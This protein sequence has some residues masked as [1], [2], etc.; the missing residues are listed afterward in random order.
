MSVYL[1]ALG[2]AAL[3]GVGDAL[4]SWDASLAGSMTLQVPAET[5]AARLKTVVA[6]L[7]QTHGL[8]EVRLLEPEETARLVQPWLGPALAAGRLPVPQ[9][10]D[11]RI[12]GGG[13]PDF[14]DLRQ[15]LASIVPDAQLEDGAQSLAGGRAEAYRLS[16]AIAAF[17][18]LA[19]LVSV[20]A[21]VS[22]ARST[23]VLRRDEIELLHLLG[24]ADNDIVRRFAGPALLAGFPGAAAGA[25]A[26]A[27]TCLALGGTPK[28]LYLSSP[29]GTAGIA[30]WRVWLTLA[31]AV[32]AGAA[33]PVAVAWGTVLRRLAQMA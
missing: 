12:D 9:I 32:I 14:A 19:L 22:N 7:R 15:K 2:G 10:I 8:A 26:A 23:L 17:V 6:L 28:T 30:D 31:G 24:A 20:A 1:G 5:S 16:G 25:L 18:V 21:S 11:M 13:A 33:I 27:L 29:A 3:I 4:G